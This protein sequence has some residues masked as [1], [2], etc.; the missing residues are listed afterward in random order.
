MSNVLPFKRQS[1][2][3]SHGELHVWRSCADEWTVGHESASGGSWGVF[4]RY[5]TRE[6][7]VA[8]ALE[9]LPVYAPCRLGR[10]GEP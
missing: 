8:R 10:I 9:L 5:P 4:E 7:A 2:S 6:Q 1:H 3:A